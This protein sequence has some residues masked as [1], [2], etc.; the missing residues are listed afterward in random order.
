METSIA[1]DGFK[2]A[3]SAAGVAGLRTRT[4]A[5]KLFVFSGGAWKQDGIK[6]SPS[7]KIKTFSRAYFNLLKAHP[8]LRG[9]LSLGSRVILKVGGKVVEVGPAGKEEVPVEKI[10]KW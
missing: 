8:K 1:L 2:K 4:V 7:I 9:C 3:E 6:G 5:G 10:R